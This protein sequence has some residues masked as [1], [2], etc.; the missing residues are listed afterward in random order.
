MKFSFVTASQPLGEDQARRRDD[1][2]GD[3]GG[4]V[5][6]GAARRVQRERVPR[7]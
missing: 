2:E 7:T 6:H 5:D 1:C 3:G 4:A